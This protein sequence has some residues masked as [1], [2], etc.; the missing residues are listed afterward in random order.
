[1]LLLLFND[2]YPRNWTHVNSNI[3]IDSSFDSITCMVKNTKLID[4]YSSYGIV[5]LFCSSKKIGHL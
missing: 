4:S 2:T 3:T 1:M 5:F